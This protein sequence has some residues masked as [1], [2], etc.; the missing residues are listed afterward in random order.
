MRLPTETLRRRARSRASAVVVGCGHMGTY[1]V[2]ALQRMGVQVTTVDPDPA[3]RADYRSLDAAPPTQFAVIAAPVQFLADEA[4]AALLRDMHVLVEKPFAP[5]AAS[6]RELCD[7]AAARGL[8]LAVGYTERGN[9]AVRA[10]RR[11]IGLAGEIAEIVVHREGPPPQSP[12]AVV[13]DLAV[14]DLDVLH[15]LGF[16]PRLTAIVPGT[17]RASLELDL[18]GCRRAT[19]NVDSSVAEKRRTLTAHGDRATLA[20]DYR[21]RTL[22]RVTT[23]GSE[24]LTDQ[25]TVYALDEQ[26]K[27][28]LDRR[29]LATGEDG[30]AVLEV[31][32]DRCETLELDDDLSVG[33][34]A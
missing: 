19:L 34:S 28:F 29:P 6:G 1:H 21:A 13:A 10:L 18:G 23:E 27:A 2:R 8:T 20:L 24:L 3:K 4:H 11:H 16:A 26:L 15:F 9:P 30:L 7:L 22:A 25:R 31:L 14:H 12:R 32:G 17:M 33:E 5:D